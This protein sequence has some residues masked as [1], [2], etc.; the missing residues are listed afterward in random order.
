MQMSN[1]I[2]MPIDTGLRFNPLKDLFDGD[3]TFNDYMTLLN[4]LTVMEHVY[5]IRRLV[6]LLTN[7]TVRFLRKRT[8]NER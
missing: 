6:S 8:S 5:V 4:T 1:I 7:K 2:L 3:I